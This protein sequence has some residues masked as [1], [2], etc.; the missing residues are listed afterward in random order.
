MLK[1]IDSAFAP[2]R[3][4]KSQSALQLIIDENFPNSYFYRLISA[5]TKLSMREFM[6]TDP[7]FALFRQL[8]T[9]STLGMAI[10]SFKEEYG[11]GKA[12]DIIGTLSHEW[13]SEAVEGMTPSGVSLDSKG[14]F[15]VFANIGAQIIV[16]KKKGKW[17]DSRKLVMTVGIKGKMFIADA[18]FD[19]R[20]LVIL[21]R[22]FELTNLKIFKGDEEQ[23]LE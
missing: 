17:E 15:K 3:D 22:G 14:N 11:E 5:D 10:P 12:V 7:R 23:F 4:E 16:E 13:I 9:T 21:P 20:T 19:N 18:E 6:S 1:P 8:L 2:M